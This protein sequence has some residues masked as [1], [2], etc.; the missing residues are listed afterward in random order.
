MNKTKEISLIALF[1]VLLFLIAI[2]NRYMFHIGQI[3]FAMAFT[4]AIMIIPYR[5]AATIMM[6]LT[7]IIYSL[8]SAL[9]PL[10]LVTWLVRGVT[11]DI[12][13]L[14]AGKNAREIHPIILAIIMTISSIA[15]GLSHF[16]IFVRFL[17][18]IPEF[19]FNIVISMISLASVLTLIGAYFSARF[20]YSRVSNI[21]GG[22]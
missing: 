4:L 13:L 20:L 10:I 9:G 7:G 18:L 14:L 1:S 12:G 22:L 6:I 5:G 16:F 11:V 17:R 19:P 3:F 8:T 21:M 15:T 2:F